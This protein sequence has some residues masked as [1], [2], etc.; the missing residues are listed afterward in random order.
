MMRLRAVALFLTLT[1]LTFAQRENAPM[2]HA[3]GTFTVDVKP[4]SPPP[5]PDVTRYSINKQLHGDLEGTTQGEM[6][7]AGDPQHGHAGYVAIE[8]VTG[9]LDGKRGTFVLQHL[10]T[11]DAN[12]PTMTVQIVPGSGTGGFKGI[13]GTF[14]ITIAKGQHSYDLTY[15]LPPQ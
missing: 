9:T 2:T 13:A 11:M 12:G 10:A 1:P 8:Q 6:F 14:N 4:L 3:H 7:S 5:A 15:S